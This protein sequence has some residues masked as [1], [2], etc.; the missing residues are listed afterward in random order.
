MITKNNLIST[1]FGTVGTFMAEK[2]YWGKAGYTEKVTYFSL[3]CTSVHC[4]AM[5]YISGVSF[6]YC[7]VLS[8]FNKKWLKMGSRHEKGIS[9]KIKEQ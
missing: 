4:I 1:Q 9:Q 6:K 8:I 5:L 7:F 2:G 3:K